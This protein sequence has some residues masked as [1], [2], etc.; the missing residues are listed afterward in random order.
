MELHPEKAIE[1]DVRY[2]AEKQY[3]HRDIL[4][5][6]MP[7]DTTSIG[8]DGMFGVNR[9][10]QTGVDVRTAMPARRPKANQRGGV[11]FFRDFQGLQRSCSCRTKDKVRA[12]LPNRTGGW[13]FVVD[14]RSGDGAVLAG[15]ELINNEHATENTSL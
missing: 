11:S 9:T 13:L 6:G 12:T 10:L 7:R 8:F 1:F 2:P 4:F 14:C 15:Q 3:N 5:V